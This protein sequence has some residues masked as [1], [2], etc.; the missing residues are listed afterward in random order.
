MWR[1]HPST[2]HHTRFIIETQRYRCVIIGIG[3]V[4]EMLEIPLSH[5]GRMILEFAAGKTLADYEQEPLFRAGVR[6][7]VRDH[8]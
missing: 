7:R 8:R 4:R 2:G 3:I 6:V 1:Q 5:A